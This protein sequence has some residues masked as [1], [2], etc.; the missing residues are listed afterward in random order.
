MATTCRF[1][2]VIMAGDSG[3][4]DDVSVISSSPAIAAKSPL[5]WSLTL[6]ESIVLN[7]GDLSGAMGLEE[8]KILNRIAATFVLS[9]L[10]ISASTF[11]AP[12]TSE[13]NLKKVGLLK[14]GRDYCWLTAGGSWLIHWRV[15]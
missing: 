2:G 9:T 15:F 7:K 4:N 12:D 5:S 10:L 11:A 1:S 3:F 8:K 14:Q 6:F 13:A